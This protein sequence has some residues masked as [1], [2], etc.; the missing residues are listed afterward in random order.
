LFLFQYLK[1]KLPILL[2]LA[3]SKYNMHLIFILT[4]HYFICDRHFFKLKCPFE[5]GGFVLFNPMIVMV[6]VIF[7][8]GVSNFV[9]RY[10]AIKNKQ[11]KVSHFRAYDS[12]GGQIPEKVIIFGRHFDNQFQVPM[13][14]L[15]TC[16]VAQTIPLYSTGYLKQLAWAFVFSRML[17]S[18]IHLGSNNVRLRMLSYTFGWLCI[19]AMWA[20]L[21]LMSHV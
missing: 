5:K 1:Q 7:G 8:L 20:N 15:I 17:H 10:R 2:E 11:L 3:L 16:V 9:V 18:F 19:L 13:V 4:L 14:F 12:A 21:S 6:F